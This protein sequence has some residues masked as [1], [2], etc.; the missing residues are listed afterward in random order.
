MWGAPAAAANASSGR[1]ASSTSQ[2]RNA[3]AAASPRP[4]RAPGTLRSRANPSGT[5]PG[6]PSGCPVDVHRAR[7]SAARAHCWTGS[8]VP[9]PV[10]STAR[11]CHCDGD[12]PLCTSVTTPEQVLPC[13]CTDV[14]GRGP[15]DQHS[16]EPMAMAWHTTPA[17]RGRHPGDA[18]RAWAGQPGSAVTSARARRTSR[19]RCGY[20]RRS[21][22]GPSS[23]RV[24]DVTRV[25]DD[26]G[27]EATGDRTAA[28]LAF[29]SDL[30]RVWAGCEP[31]AA[32]SAQLAATWCAR[33]LTRQPFADLIEA[34][35]ADQTTST[36]RP[37]MICWGTAAVGQPGRTHGAG[38]VRR[39]HPAAGGPVRPD[40]HRA[41]DHRAL[42]GRRRGPGGGPRST[43]RWRTWSGSRCAVTELGAG[44]ASA[45]AYAG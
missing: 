2:V 7:G 18:G 23:C 37:T 12:S 29:R 31:D 5:G 14:T 33:G 41:A 43:S 40:L 9:P 6:P 30:D 38:S 25:I 39:E 28:L 35:L 1:S 3:P 21:M 36:T 17:R 15:A 45:A 10:R 4:A 42:P 11:T 24:Y 19:S 44:V 26:L 32:V 8:P 22:R 20:C 27:D 13:G 34:N 16:D